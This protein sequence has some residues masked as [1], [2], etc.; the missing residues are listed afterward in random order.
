MGDACDLH[1]RI[2]FGLLEP[3]SPGRASD[4]LPAIRAARLSKL[5][6]VFAGRLAHF[7]ARVCWF[8]VPRHPFGDNRLFSNANAGEPRADASEN[9]LSERGINV[10]PR[11]VLPIRVR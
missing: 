3:A 5:A 8:P 9:S 10:F 6:C 4:T 7:L 1:C 11:H 2:P